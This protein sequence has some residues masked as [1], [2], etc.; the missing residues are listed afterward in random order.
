[1]IKD[2]L[3]AAIL[4]VTA[5]EGGHFLTAL[6]RSL[7]PKITLAWKAFT[8]RGREIKVPSSI[9][10]QYDVHKDRDSRLVSTMG[11]GGGLIV[12]DILL[13][14][15]G[16]EG[17]WVTKAFV[18]AYLFVLTAHFIWYPFKSKG[19]YS[20]DFNGMDADEDHRS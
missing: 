3:L 5:H 20:N 8:V 17:A 7:N 2:I 11:F 12:A 14:L 6:A 9:I 19:L 15:L 13:A 18:Q 1:M 4:Y 10:V 16:T